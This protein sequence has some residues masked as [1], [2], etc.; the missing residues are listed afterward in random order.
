MT[1]AAYVPR[2][3]EGF[4]LP[5]FLLKFLL[6]AIVILKFTDHVAMKYGKKN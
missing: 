2:V 5:G 1:I 6:A 3:S 4:K